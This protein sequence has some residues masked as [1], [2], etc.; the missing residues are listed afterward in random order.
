[1]S[2][3][4]SHATLFR[5]CSKLLNRLTCN[6]LGLLVEDNEGDRDKPPLSLEERLSRSEVVKLVLSTEG[7]SVVFLGDVVFVPE[8]L[9]FLNEVEQIPLVKNHLGISLIWPLLTHLSQFS[10]SYDPEW[11]FLASRLADGQSG[12][13]D[14]SD[15]PA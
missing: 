15:V 10:A 3:T 11:P 4:M 2:A 7:D 6:K 8:L 13:N 14:D 9:S 5:S 1:M 12:R